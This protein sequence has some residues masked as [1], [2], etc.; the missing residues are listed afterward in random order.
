MS[1]LLDRP[2][3]DGSA[4][5]VAPGRRH[6]GERVAVRLRIPVGYGETSVRLRVLRDGYPLRLPAQLESEDTDERWY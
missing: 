5:Y 6:L 3:H 2:H 4:L 1:H